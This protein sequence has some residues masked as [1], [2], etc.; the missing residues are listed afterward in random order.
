[1]PDTNPLLLNTL[2]RF[3]S[4]VTALH[5]ETTLSSLLNTLVMRA[6]QLVKPAAACC[7]VAYDAK[8]NAF[9]VRYS[10][11]YSFPKIIETI[12]FSDEQSVF[13]EVMQHN[14][15]QK[16]LSFANGEEISWLPAICRLQYLE[17][18]EGAYPTESIIVSLNDTQKS[19][20]V[21]VVEHFDEDR[22]SAMDVQLLATYA[23]ESTLA[24]HKVELYQENQRI[25]Q[26]LDK[27][28]QSVGEVQKLLLPTVYPLADQYD[29][30]TYYCPSTRA[31]G[32]YYDFIPLNDGRLAVIIG[33]VSGHGAAAAVIVAMTKMIIHNL[34]AHTQDPVRILVEAN[35][36][37][38]QHISI[39]YYITLFFGILD[40][41]LST[42]SY[43]SAGHIPPILLRHKTGT[44]D[45]LWNDQGF[46]L[47][48][49]DENDFDLKC[50]SFEK[51]DVLLLYTDG[52]TEMLNEDREPYS[53]EAFQEVIR[54][55]S[56]TSAQTI[57]QSIL[58]ELDAF[59]G[60]APLHD[61][62]TLI[63]IQCKA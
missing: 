21:L 37:I 17:G 55:T 53:L 35:N 49:V 54:S 57:G 22:F 60:N 33:D 23:R 38:H 36:Q 2:T 51:A 52:I 15:P 46:P 27:E 50:V 11:G 48:M 6:A 40:P 30:Y 19:L 62:V 61:D 20:G 4:F 45:E 3:H 59:R 26:E 5:R 41:R 1:M 25:N 28:L 32:D 24:I 47:R 42:L 8:H 44:L 16:L 12:A 29:Y 13:Y 34:L 58:R 7:F 39:Q 63:V 18:S 14:T 9:A 56:K 43:C 31:G 10:H